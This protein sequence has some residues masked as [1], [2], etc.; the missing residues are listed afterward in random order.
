M[1]AKQDNYH[2]VSGLDLTTMFL[3]P[4]YILENPSSQKLGVT[5]DKKLTFNEHVT[6]LCDKASRKIQALGRFFPNIPQTQ[7]QVLMNAYF[8][9]QFGYCPLVW[10][11][12]S[13]TLNNCIKEH[14]VSYATTSD[15]IFQKG[16]KKVNLN[17]KSS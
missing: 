8:T 10:M 12:Y 17:Y 15:Q 2:F 14:L 3:L 16:K 5:L 7:K 4:A 9:Y 13:R 11:K 6:N 1:K